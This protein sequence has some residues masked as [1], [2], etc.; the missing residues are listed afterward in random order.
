MS[1]RAAAV[2]SF[3]RL[4]WR[5]L[6]GTAYVLTGSADDAEELVQDVLARLYPKW[7]AVEA[8]TSP[9]A[10]VRRALINRF[11]ST[12]R[13]PSSH[14]LALWDLPE[15]A[16]ATDLANEVVGRR[17]LVDLLAGLAARPRAAVVMRYLYE[18]PDTEIAMTLH[19]RVA[20][21]RSLVSR[22]IASMHAE[23]VAASAP[24]LRREH[25]GRA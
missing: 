5:S 13:K 9:L 10:Y 21:V 2:A 12:R 19:C 18:M 22:A 7:S 3:I 25:G 8:S 20:T 6:Y 11:I 23:Y 14:E 24:P 17:V 15:V 1:D 16:D 4:N